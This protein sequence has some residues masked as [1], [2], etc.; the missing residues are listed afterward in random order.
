M[1]ILTFKFS[2]AHQRAHTITEMIIILGER[3][4]VGWKKFSFQIFIAHKIIN[5]QLFFRS[6][7]SC[8]S[9]AHKTSYKILK[10]FARFAIFCCTHIS[11]HF[12][13]SFCKVAR[14]KFSNAT[15]GCSLCMCSAA[16][17]LSWVCKH[18]TVAN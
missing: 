10:T 13:P 5:F 8:Y 17:E 7:L 3:E 2:K 4:K 11:P 9:S 1:N 15:L 16:F 6:P 12:P 14:Q 18:H